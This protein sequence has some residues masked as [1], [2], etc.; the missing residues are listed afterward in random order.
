MDI[1][2]EQIVK[3]APNGKDTAKKVLIVLCTC[4]LAAVLAF[5]MM[6]MPA[7]SGVALLL[8]FGVMYGS[9]YLITGIDVEYEYIVTNGEMDI[10]KIIA[11]RKRSRLI[12]GKVSSFE[13]FGKYA[14]AP[15]IDSSVTIVSAVGTSLS[16]VETEEWYADFTHPSAGKVR[17]I[18]SAEDKVIEAIRPFLPRQ[19][20]VN[21]NK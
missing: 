10:D 3:K 18:F 12:T 9:Y 2:V 7:F 15:D 16:G 4:L 8:L 17:L 14:D 11:K 1:F 5:V 20:K 13:A 21:L 19:L 6:F